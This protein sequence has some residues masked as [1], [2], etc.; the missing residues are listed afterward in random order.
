MALDESNDEMEKL[1]SNGIA[2]FVT[3]DLKEMLATLGAINIDFINPGFG[4]AG[5]TVKFDQNNCGD[6]SC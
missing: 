3:P 6:C 1:E 5:F 4:R 2:A